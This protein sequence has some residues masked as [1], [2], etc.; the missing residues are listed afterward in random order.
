M[1]GKRRKLG[2]FSGAL[3]GTDFS[4][5]QGGTQAFRALSP[6]LVFSLKTFKSSCVCVSE[7]YDAHNFQLSSYYAD[8]FQFLLGSPL[9][10][11]RSQCPVARLKNTQVFSSFRSSFDSGTEL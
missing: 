8:G 7:H 1:T 11:L 4:I 5:S 10:R 9:E 3:L 6:W 2:C